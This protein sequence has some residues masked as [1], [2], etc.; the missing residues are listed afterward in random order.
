MLLWFAQAE[1]APRPLCTSAQVGDWKDRQQWEQ[2]SW[3]CPE[4]L[5]VFRP[6][7]L[8][9]IFLGAERIGLCDFR[10]LA[11]LCDRSRDWESKKNCN[12]ILR[13]GKGKKLLGNLTV[14]RP[15]NLTFVLKRLW[16]ISS[17]NPS[18]HE[19]GKEVLRNSQHGLPSTTVVTTSVTVWRSREPCGQ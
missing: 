4:N 13:G 10:V 15:A 2:H 5:D 7:G 14:L 6:Q 1:S 19:V 16:D 3:Y 12:K 17:W 8:D 18:R 9:E 11:V